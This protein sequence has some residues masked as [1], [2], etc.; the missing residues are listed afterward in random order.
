MPAHQYFNWT[1]CVKSRCLPEKIE[2][3]RTQLSRDIV[4]AKVESSE[5]D[6]ATSEVNVDSIYLHNCSHRFG[7]SVL[8]QLCHS[9]EKEIK[10]F[11]HLSG[12]NNYA[13]FKI[14]RSQP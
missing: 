7:I 2:K 3:I 9:R 8:N 6:S 11:K 10:Y 14:Y 12:F 1:K 5:G 4:E 13:K